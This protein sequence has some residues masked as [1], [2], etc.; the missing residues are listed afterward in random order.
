MKVKF[1]GT[2]GSVP[3]CN[4]EFQEF[5]GNTTCFQISFPDTGRIAIIDAGTG[6]RD[7]GKALVDA[8]HRQDEIFIF[9]THFHW[10]HIQG[11]PFFAPAFDPNQKINILALGKGRKVTNL[12]KIFATTMQSE[13]FPVRLDSMGASFKFLHLDKDSEYFQSAR[14]PF[15]KVTANRHNHPGGAYGL[16]V[17]RQGKVLVICTD[18]EHGD[19]ID[20]NVVKFSRGADLL[21]HEAQ[22]TTAELK[23]RRGWGH[24]SYEQA[25]QV[26]EMAGVK[27]L[28]ITH[29]DPDHDDEFLRQMEQ[30]CQRRFPHCILA[31]EQMEI[32]L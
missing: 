13:Y 17:E 27:M 31:R 32:A 7:L 4:P 28:A 18:I 16:R 21:I 20:P 10:D 30:E 8:G 14:G 29:H 2:R 1:Y 6:I 9:F 12:R 5:G 24:S 22:Y 3:V 23:S 15:T 11:F 26:A 25:L 19:E